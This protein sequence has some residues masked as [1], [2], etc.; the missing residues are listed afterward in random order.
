[1]DRRLWSLFGFLYVV[2]GFAVA[3]WPGR[4]DV[5][6]ALLSFSTV[7]VLT[8]TLILV[9]SYTEHTANMV[10]AAREEIN[11]AQR[12]MEVAEENLR[13]AVVWRFQDN[14]PVVVIDR[15]E[16]DDGE[17]F[18]VR[19]VGGGFALNVFFIGFDPDG[20]VVTNRPLGALGAGQQRDLP[21][22]IRFEIGDRYIV[23]AEGVRTRTRQ[24]NATL[25][26]ISRGREMMHQLATFPEAPIAEQ[27]R[28]SQTIE[29]F[30]AGHSGDLHKQ[31][32]NL[33]H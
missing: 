27:F 5:L 24:W 26:G 29:E 33:L 18:V 23:L 4:R 16:R 3:V 20:R 17:H 25:N 1:M 10:A 32:G 8:W 28:T 11:V 15:D 2:L 13:T 14:K 22:I 30:V 31:L 9:W 7:Y 19:N 21:A 12:Q 6:G